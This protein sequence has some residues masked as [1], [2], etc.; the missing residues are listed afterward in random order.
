MDPAARAFR[1]WAFLAVAWAVNVPI[2]AF[3]IAPAPVFVPM[4]EDLGISKAQ[5]G[6]LISAYLLSILAF[7]LPAG[8]VIDR[9]DPRKIVPLASL[10]L[11]A[12]AVG[13]TA[14]PSYTALLGL[15]ILAG[16][17][18]AFVFVPSAFL[19]SRAFARTPG[20]PPGP[21][22]PAWGCSCPPPPGGSP[23]GTSSPPSWPRPGAGPPCSPRSPR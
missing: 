3:Y 13:L 23:G 21:R 17:P 8:Y 14:L 7:Q 10:A 20:R 6:S 19:V 16:I 11:L 18:V 15:R 2:N 5:A 9:A 22:P 1:P 12:T 4:I